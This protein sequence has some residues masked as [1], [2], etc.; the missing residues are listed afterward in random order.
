MGE[1]CVVDADE[2]LRIRLEEVPQR[3]HE[4]HI[5]AKALNSLNHYNLAHK[6]IPM[7]QA[8]K[9]PDAKAAADKEWGELEKIQAWQLTNVRNRK[10]VIEEA[11]NEGR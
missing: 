2:T 8:L 6:F 4:G 7:P 1:A 10:E 3:S 9:I 11:R 5:A